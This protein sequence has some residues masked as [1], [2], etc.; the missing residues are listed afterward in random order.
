LSRSPPAGCSV[1]NAA[2]S[3]RLLDHDNHRVKLR[4][5]ESITTSAGVIIATYQPER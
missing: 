4:L 1:R 2:S 3:K 5:V